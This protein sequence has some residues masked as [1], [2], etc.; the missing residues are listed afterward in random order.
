MDI[1]VNCRRGLLAEKPSLTP[2]SKGCAS[3]AITDNR[4]ETGISLVFL[5]FQ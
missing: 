2:G 4:M 1:P 5:F 3:L